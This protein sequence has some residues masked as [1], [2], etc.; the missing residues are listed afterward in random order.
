MKDTEITQG[1]LVTWTGI[2]GKTYTGTVL[3]EA[4]GSLTVLTDTTQNV[5]SFTKNSAK[6]A[7]LRLYK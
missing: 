3:R 2:K 6:A 1:S 5:M 7:G 4:G